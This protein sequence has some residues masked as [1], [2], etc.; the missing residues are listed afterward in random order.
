MS[1]ERK[2]GLGDRSSPAELLATAEESI[3]AVKF[4][5]QGAIPPVSANAK[6]GPSASD[7]AFGSQQATYERHAKLH[8][9]SHAYQPAAPHRL[10]PQAPL[11]AGQRTAISS[12]ERQELR[13]QLAGYA[14]QHPFAGDLL[15]MG[16]SEA[17]LPV[18]ISSIEHHDAIDRTTAIS[19]ATTAGFR[20]GLD[21]ATASTRDAMAQPEQHDQLAGNLAMLGLHTDMFLTDDPAT[22]LEHPDAIC[23][24]TTT[25]VEGRIGWLHA[26]ITEARAQ[27]DGHAALMLLQWVSMLSNTR[28]FAMLRELSVFDP[29]LAR[30]LGEAFVTALRAAIATAGA[31]AI[32]HQI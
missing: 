11:P 7:R 14:L 19:P 29:G 17:E 23:A 1:R 25:L 30:S 13:E 16:L 2:P 20:P 22:T 28:E 3:A 4:V 21:A 24:A 18:A 26:S 15:N 32:E 5:T 27:P 9:R 31:S 12:E 10:P 8:D 6:P